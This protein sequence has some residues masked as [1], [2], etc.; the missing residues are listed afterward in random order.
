MSFPNDFAKLMVNGFRNADA[1]KYI[2]NLPQKDADWL[3]EL[4][5]PQT[6]TEVTWAPNQNYNFVTRFSMTFD[7]K[8]TRAFELKP[9]NDL[10]TFAIDPPVTA[11]RVRLKILDVA[12]NPAHEGDITGLDNIWIRAKR[13]ADFFRKVRP[14]L[15]IGAMVEYPRGPGGIVLCNLRF[16]DTEAAPINATK[17]LTILATLLRNLKAPF[18]SGKTLIAGA[19]LAYAPIDISKQ[20]TQYRDERGW[21]GDRSFTFAALPTGDQTFAGVKYRIYDFATSPVP[22]CIM[23]GGSGIPNNPPQEVRGI[24]VGRKAD[25]LFFLQAARIDVRMNRDDER[26]GKRYEMARYVIH[27]ADGQTAEAPVFAERDVD[28][29]KQQDPRPLPGAQ[30]AWTKPWPGSGYSAVAYSMQWNNPRPDVAIQSI[31]LLY[32]KDRRGVPALL[33]LTAATLEK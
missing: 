10:Q 19:N 17:K 30:I 25:A 11:R 9:T 8:E 29:Y 20:A 18:G 12:R 1:W 5:K 7:G 23:L 13:P 16:K 31:D 21:F 26:D 3:L 28:D 15:N 14:M 32:G 2:V 22:N 24:P 27:Y 33:A 4:P 6:L